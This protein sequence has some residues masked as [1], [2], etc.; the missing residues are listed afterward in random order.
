MV[1]HYMKKLLVSGVLAALLTVPISVGGS[2]T[3]GGRSLEQRVEERKTMV[4]FSHMGRRAIGESTNLVRDSGYELPNILFYNQG[5]ELNV[6]RESKDILTGIVE[7][8]TMVTFGRSAGLVTENPEELPENFPIRAFQDTY[9][10]LLKDEHKYRTALWEYEIDKN[11]KLKEMDSRE[12]VPYD[13]NPMVSTVLHE[14]GHVYFRFLDDEE[15]KNLVKLFMSM[16]QHNPSF[17]YY[18][19]GEPNYM[20]GHCCRHSHFHSIGGD[21]EDDCPMQLANEQFAD[22][23]AYLVIGHDY[24]KGDFFFQEKLRAVKK[25]MEQFRSF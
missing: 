25:T 21:E 22:I 4:G 7:R 15:R 16:D 5:E 2:D 13:D 10:V 12:S 17:S 11:G 19:G 20:Q 8:D 3:Q 9:L 14:I 23:F 24:K 6:I 1:C 18:P